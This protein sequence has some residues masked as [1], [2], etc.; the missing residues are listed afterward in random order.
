MDGLGDAGKR[1]RTGDGSYLVGRTAERFYV[2]P[3]LLQLGFY[4]GEKILFIFYR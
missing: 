4:A 3:E 1:E 2:E